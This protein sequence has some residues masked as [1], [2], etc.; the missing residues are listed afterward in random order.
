MQALIGLRKRYAAFRRRDFLTGAPVP[1]NGLKD[2]YWLA[3]EGREM[4]RSRIGRT[5]C[6]ARSACSSATTRPTGSASSSWSTPGLRR[7]DFRLAEQPPGR[8]VQIIDT[9][10][11]EG[12]VRGA[13]EVL[14]PGGTFALDARSLV[15]F[16]CAASSG[17]R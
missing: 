1:G 4:T 7:S 16:Q 2:V 9:R 10:L 5:A 13:P 17:D 6:G 12:L 11:A 3:P 14:E 8:W 15:L